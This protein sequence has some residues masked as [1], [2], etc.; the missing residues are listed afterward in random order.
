MLKMC[1]YMCIIL[2]IMIITEHPWCPFLNDNHK[3][4]GTQHAVTPLSYMHIMIITEHTWCPF[5]NDKRKPHGTQHA[6]KQ[7][8]YHA[9]HTQTTHNKKHSAP[10]VSHI[11][12][13]MQSI[14]SLWSVLIDTFLMQYH[15][16][17]L[18]HTIIS[19]NCPSETPE[20]NLN[21]MSM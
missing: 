9:Q 18:Q 12:I 16:M 3:P 7:L 5:L 19:Y 1:W 2:H 8:P 20:I 10:H 17:P 14:L 4:H 11:C 6:R 21:K 13:P 15:T